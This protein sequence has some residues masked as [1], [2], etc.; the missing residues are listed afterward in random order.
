M[1]WS[2]LLGQAASVRDIVRGQPRLLF[3]RRLQT[4]KRIACRPTS[5]CLEGGWT[6]WALDEFSSAARI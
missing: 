1:I 5:C 4:Q 6:T 2:L 3:R